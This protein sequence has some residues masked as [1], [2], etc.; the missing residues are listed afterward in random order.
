MKVILFGGAEVKLGQVK[1]ELKQ[2]ENVIKRLKVKQI[3]SVPFARTIAIEKEWS[4]NSFQKNIHVPGASYLN[5][6]KSGDIIKARSPLIFISGGSEHVN[7][8]NKIKSNP[9]LLGLIKNASFIIGESAGSMVLGKYFRSGGADGPRR[10]LKGLG[11][12]KD[13]VIEPHYTERKRQK[14]LIQETKE[15]KVKY[16]I[17]IDC[18]TAIEFDISKF[19]KEYKVLGTGNVEIIKRSK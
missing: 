3:L 12:I 11:I 5:A 7:L 6:N 10:M 17:G 19:P 13:T 15:T 1:L 2:I 9:R 14:R 16:G 18:L 8:I 4:G